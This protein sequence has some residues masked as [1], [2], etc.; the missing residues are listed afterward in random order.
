M[1]NVWVLGAGTDPVL[2]PTCADPA[3]TKRFVGMGA[4]SWE[5]LMNVVGVNWTG[6]PPQALHQVTTEE[7]LTKFEPVTVMVIG[8]AV[9]AGVL[10]GDIEVTPDDDRVKVNPFEET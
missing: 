4:W 8:F 5:V 10:E 1:V 7:P 3:V 2:T 9:P 6:V